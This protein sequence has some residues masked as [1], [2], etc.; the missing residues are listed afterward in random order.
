LRQVTKGT[1][2]VFG[3]LPKNGR[4]KRKERKEKNSI[5]FAPREGRIHLRRKKNTSRGSEKKKKETRAS[6]SSVRERGKP[7]H[8]TCGPPP[9]PTPLNSLEKKSP[10]GKKK[11]RKRSVSS[12]KRPIGGITDGHFGK[13]VPGGGGRGGF[14][15]AKLKRR[16][17]KKG[18]RNLIFRGEKNFH[19]RGRKEEMEK[20][21]S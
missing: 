16:S 2:M 20:A 18:E 4:K 7:E 15:W 1:L 13:S 3:N 14:L 8:H 19:G 6:K 12:E 10:H 11:I 5:T 9:P 21:I 17:S